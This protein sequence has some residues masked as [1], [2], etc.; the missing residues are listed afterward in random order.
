MIPSQRWYTL[1]SSMS[2]SQREFDRNIMGRLSSINFRSW[3]GSTDKI[4][5]SWLSV[6]GIF[7]ESDDRIVSVEILFLFDQSHRALTKMNTVN[8]RPRPPTVAKTTQLRATSALERLEDDSQVDTNSFK[9][10]FSR[11]RMENDTDPMSPTSVRLQTQ[12]VV[13]SFDP[14]DNSQWI[15][16]LRW[17]G[18]FTL[19]SQILM[20]DRI[21]QRRRTMPEKEP[22]QDNIRESPEGHR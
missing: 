12:T 13:D 11:D 1:I 2:F 5:T 22:L 17:S 14:S 6:W 21:G 3:L 7:V 15:L 18:A 4:L 10:D 8:I 19:I 9:T 16:R 20:I